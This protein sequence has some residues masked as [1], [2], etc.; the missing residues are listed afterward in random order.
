MA[1]I[2]SK[3]IDGEIPGTFVYTDD[4]CVAFMDV[5]PLTRGHVLVVPRAEVDHWLDLDDELS[6]HLFA[7]AKKIGKAQKAAFDCQRVGV[8]IQGFEVPHV[9]I[10]V[11]PANQ[12]SDFELAN[13]DKNSTAEDR[14][15]A[16]DQIIAALDSAK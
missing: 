15:A 2:F 8:V 4:T 7:V 1:T 9:H 10:H 12:I 6:A 5:Q 3:I 11:F 16:A 14:Q 13:K